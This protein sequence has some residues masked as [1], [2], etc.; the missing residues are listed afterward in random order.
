L[1][2]GVCRPGGRGVGFHD[3]VFL[4]FF[5]EYMEAGYLSSIFSTQK[6]KKNLTRGT[7]A[8]I[9]NKA[10]PYLLATPFSS[11]KK[12]M[13]Q[14]FI[15]HFREDGREQT[16]LE[17]LDAVSKLTGCFAAKAG[18]SSAGRLV[19][20]VHD[21]GKYSK[22][23]QDYIRA[24]ANNP[25]QQADLDNDEYQYKAQDKGK[26]DHSTAGA[27]MVWRHYR[28]YTAKIP[29]YAQM[30]AL[31]V[32]SHHS[33]LIDC[34]AQ[35]GTRVFCKR[36]E[37]EDAKTHL[38][39]C[40]AGAD[41]A[42]L[43][44]I[45]ALMQRPLL[46]EMRERIEAIK[47]RH[48][49]TIQSDNE[50]YDR[51]NAIFFTFGLL[52]GFLLSC[53]L[54]ADRIDSA[55]FADDNYA[56]L[57]SRLTVPDWPLL[58]SRLEKKLDGFSTASSLA[59]IRDGIAGHCDDIADI[60]ADIAGRC[61]AKSTAAKG[62]F[63]LT[64][65][66]GGGKTLSSLRFA[67]AHAHRHG[68]ER[69][70]YVIP[71]T[72][73]I[74]QNA[75]EVRAVLEQG[76]EPG[77]VVLEQHS[78]ILP[79]KESWQ[80]KL[81]AS[82]WESPVVF[83]TMV[84]FLEALF[85]AGTRSARRM[86]NLARSV[87][88]FDEIQTLPLTCIHMFCN[89]LNFLV[90]DCGSSAVLCTATQ[91]LLGSLPS[92]FKGQLSLTPESEIMP[93][94]SD[95]FNRLRRVTFHNHCRTPMSEEAI[96]ELARSEVQDSGSCLIVVNTKAW[97]DRLF[98]ACSIGDDT[99]VFYLSTQLC[100]AHRLEILESLKSA[101]TAGDQVI[102]VSTQLIECG[103]D[104]SFGSVIRFAAGLDSILQAAGRCNRHRER[105]FGRVHIVIVPEG[106]ENLDKLPGIRAGKEAF[107]R[108][109]N[110]KDNPL[111]APGADLNHPELIR[112]YFAYYFY[113]QAGVMSYPDP[114]RREG[115]GRDNLLRLFG[116]NDNNP[117]FKSEP[118][119]LQQSFARAA[120]SFQPI[121]APTQGVIVP[122]KRGDDIIAELAS[123]SGIHK[124]KS[125]LR[126]AQRYTV[127]IYPWMLDQLCSKNA[128][129]DL[130]ET[131]VLCLRE[132]WYSDTIGVCTE[133]VGKVSISVY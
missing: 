84:Q 63:T 2:F 114:S 31:A 66:T 95:L 40:K 38:E 25:A 23:F 48:G 79:D 121:D 28:P 89:A 76:E 6:H 115:P 113:G 54:D 27:Q 8:D 118:K 111:V 77:T 35:D 46:L 11:T 109:L 70:I 80:S 65:P 100:P 98:R 67:L 125:L 99:R 107:L 127:N 69:V 85:G 58:I 104:I 93:D 112:Q 21:F 130:P 133:P 39:E 4:D 86:H 87:L 30:L 36:M 17:H 71:Y 78:N 12:A 7:G 18:L 119:L 129:V 47:Q 94:V 16:V 92:P 45:R 123:A 9:S 116:R 14:P 59:D 68:L 62:I 1:N 29:Y 49:E 44:D 33:G 5:L 32:C 34:L 26:I 52:T 91:P 97:A 19:G 132:G 126:E 74:D 131:G 117:G 20:L 55:A 72:T 60:R 96:A 110:E 102:C 56:A 10:V 53:L 42:V 64:V 103:V 128:I 3:I 57:R 82:N 101:L 22:A 90:H 24:C 105:P 122:Y 83:T 106:E 124:K 43:A 73:I 13:T 37:K 108:L 88:I 75:A 81:L 15:A 120:A 51:D 61:A 50:R 41:A